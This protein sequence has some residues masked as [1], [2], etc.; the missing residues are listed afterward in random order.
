MVLQAAATAIGNGTAV[1]FRGQAGVYGFSVEPTGTITGGEVLFEH[2]PATD[3]S[4]TWS[5]IGMAV[6]PA[7]GILS[8]FAVEGRFFAVRA[9]ITETVTGSST[10]GVTARVA[11][12]I[13]PL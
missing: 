9:R 1:N 10:P 6:A 2:A 5:P 3:Y 8:S 13:V 4:G 7:T 11:P 12:P